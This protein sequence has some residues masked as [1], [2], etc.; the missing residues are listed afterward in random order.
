MEAG[1]S[2]FFIEIK[3]I[4]LKRL[5]EQEQEPVEGFVPIA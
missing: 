1:K 3:D 5:T 2:T 4:C